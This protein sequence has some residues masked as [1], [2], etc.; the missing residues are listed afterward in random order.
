MA[1]PPAAPRSAS[2]PPAAPLPLQPLPAPAQVARALPIGRYDPFAT[3][4]DPPVGAATST[5]PTTSTTTTAAA[6]GRPA[7]QARRQAA[8]AAAASCTDLPPDF[9]FTGVIRG[10]GQSYAVVE[11]AGMSGSVRAGDRGGHGR[12]PSITDLLPPCWSV[13]RVDVNRGL[14]EL[15]QGSRR[16]RVQL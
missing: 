1:L 13:A 5:P 3:V 11:A 12:D 6:G 10:G 15:R 2:R 8:A 14:L 4:A 16:W 7:T 9:R